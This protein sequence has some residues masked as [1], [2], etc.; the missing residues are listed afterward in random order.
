MLNRCPQVVR[1]TP[2]M[3][4]PKAA[5]TKKT[6]KTSAPAAGFHFTHAESASASSESRKIKTHEPKKKPHAMRALSCAHPP[7]SRYACRPNSSR[8]GTHVISD[9]RIISTDILPRTYSTR[10]NG[11]ARYNERALL[12]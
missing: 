2:L 8:P 5:A 1:C 7:P 10:D 11:R 9:I 4:A 12:A 6:P 3:V